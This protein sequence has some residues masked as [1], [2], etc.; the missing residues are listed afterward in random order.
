[1]II[2]ISLINAQKMFTAKDK[3][4][5][6]NKG[7]QLS[8]IKKQ[9]EN[10]REG[11]PFLKLIRPAT[12]G[13]GIISLSE[14]KIKEA[15]GHYSKRIE[16]GL[17]PVKFVPASG[18]ASRMFQSLYSFWE[19]ALNNQIA[20]TLLEHHH[21]KS[22]RQFFDH[23]PHFA[24]Y[25]ELEKGVGGIKDKEGHFKYCEVLNY[26]LSDKGLNYGFLPK[27]L[28]KFHQYPEGPRTPVEEHMIEG[29]LY[30]ANSKGEVSLHFTVSPEHLEYFKRITA[31]AAKI[32]E[33]KFAVK[34]RILFSEQKPSTDTIA[35]D[36]DNNP[37]RNTDDTL[38]FRPG[39]H[40]ALLDNLNDIEADLIF[41]KNIDNVVP[42]RLKN[43]TVI[44]KK[45][46]AG[47]LFGY[48]ERI[49]DYLR[50]LEK[51]PSLLT[52][53]QVAAIAVFVEKELCTI[54]SDNNHTLNK[55]ALIQYL[56]KKLNRPIRLCGMV[57]NLGEPGGGPFWAQNS[58]GTLSLQI[59]E[60]LQID[61]NNAEQKDIL[62]KST[63]FNPVDLICAVKNFK[64][65]K[66]DLKKFRDPETGFISHKSKE[67][68]PLKALELPGLWNGSMSD[69]NTLFVDVP[70]ITFNP[71]KTI[72]DLLREEHQS[73]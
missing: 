57:R 39:G 49:F 21:H 24:F 38:V 36:P 13:D 31:K 63:H 69:W 22:A 32:Y 15:S 50:L 42:D 51:G 3:E 30:G 5:I 18:A 59:A 33:P 10:F 55:S 7:I 1:M 4:Q 64:G 6:E 70:M 44:Y 48:Q 19:A 35:V 45:A 43:E 66:F 16:S 53:E 47:L 73:F 34:Y 67:G 17:Q 26:L 25:E 9:I 27:G 68:R 62:Q 12:I 28:L 8:E 23:L 11:F 41:I 54:P 71:V 14:D 58:D 20:E 37:F 72:N 40:G 46:L 2:F 65:G 60:N 52:D 29:A 61:I 56:I